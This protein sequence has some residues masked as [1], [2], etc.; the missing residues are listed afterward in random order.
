MHSVYEWCMYVPM[1]RQIKVLL[2]YNLDIVILYIPLMCHVGLG[3]Y[4]IIRYYCYL[5]T[6]DN[7]MAVYN[8]QDDIIVECACAN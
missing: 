3:D 2:W 4:S 1:Y 6:N 8:T 5:I 7:R